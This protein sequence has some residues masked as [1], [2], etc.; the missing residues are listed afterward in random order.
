MKDAHITHTM[1]ERYVLGQ[2][3]EDERERIDEHLL[4]CDRCLQQLM[5]AEPLLDPQVQLSET[6]LHRLE[7]RVISKLHA[8]RKKP[9]RHPVRWLQRA[10]VQYAI[11]A[12]ITLILFISGAFSNVALKL[13]EL[14]MR[15]A[16]EQRSSQHPST[17]LNPASQESWSEQLI[18]RTGDW[19]DRLKA[20]RF[21]QQ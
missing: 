13:A 14:E 16:V 11:A 1:M 4:T 12:S 5:E 10:S 15:A 6:D 7:E 21:D 20:Y 8:D 3:S 18:N 9:V 2:L 19:L 17:I